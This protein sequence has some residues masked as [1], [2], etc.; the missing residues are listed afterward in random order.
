MKIKLAPSEPSVEKVDQN[1]SAQLPFFNHFPSPHFYP[2]PQF[3]FNFQQNPSFFH[4]VPHFPF[5]FNYPLA[6]Q[7]PF[8]SGPFPILGN[9]PPTDHALPTGTHPPAVDHL[10]Q[11]DLNQKKLLSI[12]WQGQVLLSTVECP[13]TLMECLLAMMESEKN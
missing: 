4:Y 13:A 1:C 7:A 12:C 3:H 2:T 10:Y 8:S 5:T 6:G 11:G 9:F